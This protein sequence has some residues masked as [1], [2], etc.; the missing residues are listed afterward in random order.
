MKEHQA[1]ARAIAAWLEEHPAVERVIYPG[2]LISDSPALAHR[3]SRRAGLKSH[4][5]YELAQRQMSGFGGM[6]TFFLK[7]GLEASTKFLSSLKIFALAE[8]LGAV[9]SLAEHP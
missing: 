3:L 2:A 1:N 4:P 6:I 9:E 5:Q 7:G 8:S